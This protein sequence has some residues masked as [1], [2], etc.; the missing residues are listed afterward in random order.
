MLHRIIFKSFFLLL[1]ASL[2][3]LSQQLNKNIS[4]GTKV[5]EPFVIK[6]SS[7]KWDGISIELWE[8]LLIN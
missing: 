8:K 4:V 5:A 3:V 6:Y 7:E 2:S 1:V